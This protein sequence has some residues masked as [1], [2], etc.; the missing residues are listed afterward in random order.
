MWWNKNRKW[1]HF[2]SCAV[3][4]F[5]CCNEWNNLK[6]FW[7]ITES[8]TIKTP[9]S[10]KYF[11]SL[12]LYMQLNGSKRVSNIIIWSWV[13]M[14][15]F[16][17]NSSTHVLFLIQWICSTYF[18]ISRHYDYKKKLTRDNC[19]FF[20][21]PCTYKIRKYFSSAN[22]ALELQVLPFHGPLTPCYTSSSS[23]YQ[24]YKV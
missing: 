4:I 11:V 8:K 13:K 1:L 9:S 17:I 23:S 15:T 20:S 10:Q 19:W 14:L 12:V 16:W 18:L 22:E 7:F 24:Y 3:C 2:I 21:P 6:I 5:G